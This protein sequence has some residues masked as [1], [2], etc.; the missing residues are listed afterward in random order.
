M[1]LTDMGANEGPREKK[2]KS[3]RIQEFSLKNECAPQTWKET[4]LTIYHTVTVENF[5]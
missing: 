5:N 1:S 2:A 4:T 3:P